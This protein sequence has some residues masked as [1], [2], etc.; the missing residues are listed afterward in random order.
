M[1]L[2]LVLS[3]VAAL[4]TGTV[5]VG[6][7]EVI[8]ALSGN[9]GVNS[10]ILIYIRLPR[11]ANAIVVGACLSC[12]G[13]MLQ[14]ALRNNLAEPGLLGI[15]AGAGLGAIIVFLI[16]TYFS[17]SLLMPVSFVFAV[18]ST[19]LIFVIASGLK[20]I[21]RSYI[22][23]NTIILTGIA[24]SALISA[25]NGFLML[26]SGSSI[27]QI[28]YWLNGGLS[29]RGW[30][31]L[32][33]VIPFASIGI[34]LTVVLSKDLN[35]MNFGEEMSSSLGLDMKKFQRL[36]IFAS[37]LLAASA[38]SIAGIVSFA[39][40]IVPN[41]TRLVIGNDYRYSVPCSVIMGS[42]FILI[43]DTI[44]RTIAAPAEI[45]L[46]IVTSFIGAPVFIWLLIKGNRQ[47]LKV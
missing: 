45:P 30:E 37:S 33:P 25:L 19:A 18:M 17:F 5:K 32:V 47:S 38:V 24:L 10:D 21:Y 23:S 3:T 44:A 29:G 22:S 34:L 35:I 39:G 43:S 36:S 9:G 8:S 2:L 1:V 31:E 28:V 41:L 12:A 20:G 13:I 46:G 42:S 40:L 26:A 27:T 16:P 14:A 11:I 6:M 4:L 15:S 7:S